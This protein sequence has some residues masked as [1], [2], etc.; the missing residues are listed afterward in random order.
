ML[1]F[2]VEKQLPFDVVSSSQTINATFKPPFTELKEELNDIFQIEATTEQ[3]TQAIFT[4]STV[5]VASYDKYRCVRQYD[6]LLNL[7]KEWIPKSIKYENDKPQQPTEQHQDLEA[8]LLQHFRPKDL[9]YMKKGGKFEQYEKQLNENIFKLTNVA[10]GYK[11]PTIKP[12]FLFELLYM[13]L[14]NCL[15]GS[16]PERKQESFERMFK[17]LSDYNKNQGD[18]RQL[19]KDLAQT[20]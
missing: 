6:K 18:I 4:F 9:D 1:D 16:T 2:R 10:K 3:I 5:A 19:V 11:N 7:F 13:P 12:L 14:G 8:Y 20:Q 17:K 15:N